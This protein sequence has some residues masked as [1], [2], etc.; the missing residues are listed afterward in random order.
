MAQHDESAA[1]MYL[2]SHSDLKQLEALFPP[3]A[4]RLTYCAKEEEQQ[5]YFLF[6]RTWFT[7]PLAVASL[8]YFFSL[9]D[10][11]VLLDRCADLQYLYREVLLLLILWPW[12][13]S[14]ASQQAGK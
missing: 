12:V 10:G 4:S 6:L 14:S 9:F 8:V 2:L 13:L 1:I 5:R 11:I 7:H 3:D